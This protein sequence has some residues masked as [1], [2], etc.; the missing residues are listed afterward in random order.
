VQT[1]ARC[2][3]M[4][5]LASFK[6]LLRTC[7][8]STYPFNT[9][10]TAH[11]TLVG[12]PRAL[13]S[14]GGVWLA[15]PHQLLCI[16]WAWEKAWPYMAGNEHCAT[17]A[18]PWGR[19]MSILVQGPAGFCTLYGE[20]AR[21]SIAPQVVKCSALLARASIHA[22]LRSYSVL[23]K[24]VAMGKCKCDRNREGVWSNATSCTCV[25]WLMCASL[26]EPGG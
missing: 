15:A 20:A 9:D 26:L 25:L 4:P 19:C 8:F 23:Y 6:Q 17:M 2:H 21:S 13:E 3:C 12:V 22:S 16:T 5:Q 10:C 18:V 1:Q 24:Y 14:M 11:C 7:T